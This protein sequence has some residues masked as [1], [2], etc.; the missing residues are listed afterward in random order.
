MSAE[1][2][3]G[4]GKEKPGN[5]MNW[6]V[7]EFLK[8]EALV[9]VEILPEGDYPQWVKNVERRFLAGVMPTVK[10][11][12]G[13]EKTPKT[14]GTFLGQQC[15]NAV[16]LMELFGQQ[17]LVQEQR[18]HEPLTQT[19][20]EKGQQLA[21]SLVERWYPGMRQLAKNALCSSVDQTYREMSEFLL[22]FAM[23]YASKPTSLGLGG[24]GDANFEIYVFMLL[25][26]RTVERLKSVRE[27]HDI[28]TKVFGRRAG[29]LK[30][31]EKICQRIE[32]TFRRPGRP[33][34]ER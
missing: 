2:I 23:G 9:P 12:Q 24:M 10:I 1:R 8:L 17:V 20:M 18:K 26:W 33:P 21:E 15:A 34:T 3:E 16:W 7:D 29:D 5:W 4:I 30:R 19:Q 28:L 13:L 6:L 22:G 32:L 25:F 14:L 27:L 11:D 31:V